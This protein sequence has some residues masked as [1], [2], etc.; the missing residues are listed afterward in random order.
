MKKL[1]FSA[2]LL[3]ALSSAFSQTT[4]TSSTPVVKTVKLEQLTIKD[5]KTFIV[6]PDKSLTEVT[7]PNH[8]VA[9]ITVGYQ[10]VTVMFDVKQKKF[11]ITKFNCMC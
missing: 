6:N 5:G 8:L 3:L 2:V 11:I 7:D 10:E 4:K 1:L 9:N